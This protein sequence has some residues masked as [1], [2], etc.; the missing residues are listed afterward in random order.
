MRIISIAI[1]FF[2]LTVPS[3][4]QESCSFSKWNKYRDT[5]L[6]RNLAKSAYIYGTMQIKVDADGAPNAYHPDDIGL[7]CTNGTGFKGLDCPANAGYPKSS[8]WKNALLPDPLNPN[9][10]YVQTVGRYAGYFISQT[11]LKDKTK[12]DTD[13]EKYVDSRN[14]P[15][16]IFP[17]KFNKI[18]GTGFI[19]DLGYAINL[20]SGET[21]P[22]VV[23][24]IGPSNAQLGE[25]SIALAVAL[26]GN[27]PNPRTGAGTPSGTILYVIFPN[28][29]HDYPW[30]LSP[31]EMATA[32]ESLLESV[33][34]IDAVLACKEGYM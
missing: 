7:H 22:F 29:N 2:L 15:Y 10:A 1:L 4:A 31:S 20:E 6:I 24:E 32:S 3:F 28:S 18:K 5:K 30:P 34:G 12:A 23:A 25:M 14:I 13:T 17:R 11:T 26:G 27:N 8:W 21:S 16:I 19:G 9:R 33:G